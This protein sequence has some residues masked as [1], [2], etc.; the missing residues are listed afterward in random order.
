M[1]WNLWVEKEM[2][3][4]AYL[5]LYYN[6]FDGKR[7][8]EEFSFLRAFKSQNL[9]DRLVRL[10]LYNYPMILYLIRL[11]KVCAKMKIMKK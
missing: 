2:P 7:Y 5:S 11:K 10:A 3:W 9:N 4:I 6:A 1:F 8:F